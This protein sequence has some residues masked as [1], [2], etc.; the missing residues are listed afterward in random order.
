MIVRLV[1][2]F[3]AAVDAV[4]YVAVEA[5]AVGDDVV[6]VDPVATVDFVVAVAGC[7]TLCCTRRRWR[8]PWRPGRR[9]RPSGAASFLWGQA[10]HWKSYHFSNWDIYMVTN[11]IVEELKFQS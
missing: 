6:T 2:T 10:E 9:P 11:M 4:A 8:R 7:P 5:E 1:G 3:A